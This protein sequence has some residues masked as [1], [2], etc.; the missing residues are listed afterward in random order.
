MSNRSHER[1]FAAAMLLLAAAIMSGCASLQPELSPQAF[2]QLPQRVQ[3][4]DV[5]FHAQEKYQCGP[6]ALAMA[7]N[8]SGIAV[9]PEELIPLVYSPARKGTLQAEMIGAARRLGRLAY[10]IDGLD[11]LLQEL[12]AGHPVIVLQNLAFD[13]APTWHYALVLGYDKASGT[14]S[15]H[16]GVTRRYV[17]DWTVFVKTWQRGSF[18]GL[19]T[20]PPG[21]I[22]ASTLERTYLQAVLGL[23]QVQNWAAAS[24]AYAAALDRWPDSLGALMGLG[25]AR[26]ALG[27]LP[28]AEEA[29]R[30][31][32][33]VA[34]RNGATHNNLAHVLSDQRRYE[35]ALDS[36]GRAIAAGGPQKALFE[37]TLREIKAKMGS[38]QD[39]NLISN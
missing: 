13:W 5:P 37:K 1:T 27:D 22:P 4:P 23:E 9:T 2:S 17:T 28:G 31:A 3:I 16:S 14:I 15:M 25:N 20:V 38:G 8:W 24:T 34:P 33:M 12:A 26:Y 21:T 29:F 18:W 19:L 6:A 10:T 35:A 7:L 32:T 11:A 30:R 39:S 36:I